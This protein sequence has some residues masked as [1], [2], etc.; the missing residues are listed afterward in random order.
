MNVNLKKEYRLSQ[1]K[2]IGIVL[3]FILVSGIIGI[4]IWNLATAGW[5]GSLESLPKYMEA[6]MPYSYCIM[7]NGTYVASYNGTTCQRVSISSNKSLPTQNA[8]ND[9]NSKDGGII[10]VRNGNYTGASVIVKSKVHLM[11]EAGAFGLSYTVS[12]TGIVSLYN[13]D[14]SKGCMIIKANLNLTGY[15]ILGMVF[16]TG[17]SFPS[18]PIE[19][20]PFYRTTDHILYVWNSTAWVNCFTGGTSGSNLNLQEFDYVA[21]RDGNTYKAMAEDGS[22]AIQNT[23]FTSFL[24]NLISTMQTG[25]K[26]F[27]KKAS[28]EYLSAKVTINKGIQIIGCGWYLYQG[29]WNGCI[30]EVQTNGEISVT[31]G[32]VV[33]KGIYFSGPSVHTKPVIH[34]N[35]VGASS[36]L[37]LYVEENLFTHFYGQQYICDFR[38]LERNRFVKNVLCNTNNVTY[39]DYGA[40]LRFSAFNY[41]VGLGEVSGNEFWC[42]IQPASPE[43]RGKF[44]ASILVYI[45]A[46]GTTDLGCGFSNNH[47]AAETPTDLKH[48]G[49]YVINEAGSHSV[50][51]PTVSDNTFESTLGVFVTGAGPA[52]PYIDGNDFYPQYTSSLNPNVFLDYMVETYSITDNDFRA[53]TY[54]FGN[55]H[56]GASG[57][58]RSNRY[59]TNPVFDPLRGTFIW[60]G[61]IIGGKTCEGTRSFTNI[62]NTTYVTHNRP[63]TPDYVLLSTTTANC[64]LWIGIVNATHVQIYG[65]Q[66]TFSGYMYTEYR[67]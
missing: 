63:S 24:T 67:P 28:Y 10:F 22:I 46:N 15:Q 50:L 23:S 44:G 58:F 36:V 8:I 1:K 32:N 26:V 49:I 45:P 13:F 56:Y 12:G 39:W 34:T 41:S 55:I 29:A 57:I 19:G 9:L 3:A 31:A 4:G 65:S 40:M 21:F 43:V 54:Q 52:T 42:K 14:G 60:S 20:Q 47:F 38:N 33:I 11:L 27:F 16:H 37:N 5:Q 61:N 51:G 30:W 6:P 53:G 64:Y 2:A 62:A 18:S 48:Y 25:E 17:T 66:N 59:P 7:T 35:D